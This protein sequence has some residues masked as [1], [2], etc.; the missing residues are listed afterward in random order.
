MEM[1]SIYKIIKRLFRAK[2]FVQ[3][4]LRNSKLRLRV[5]ENLL[6]K[7]TIQKLRWSSL[8]QIYIS[9]CLRYFTARLVTI[10]VWINVFN[11]YQVRKVYF[12]TSKQLNRGDPRDRDSRGAREDFL[13]VVQSTEKL[14][15]QRPGNFR[16]RELEIILELLLQRKLK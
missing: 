12:V 13:S 6:F 11:F 15:C 5:F 16:A 2:I 9:G 10:F 3:T 8:D 1:I 14:I 4:D 7:A